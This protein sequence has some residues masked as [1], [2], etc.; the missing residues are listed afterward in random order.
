MA[1]L[2]LLLPLLAVTLGSCSYVYDLKA[3]VIGGRLAFVVDP[4]SRNVASCLNAID[5][6]ASGEVKAK[7]APGDDVSRVR[8]GTFWHERLDYGCADKF[9]IFYGQRFKGKRGPSG[10]AIKVVAAKPLRIG[11]VYEVSTT[12]GTGGYGGG[13]FKIMPD[14]TVS[15]LP[16]TPMVDSDDAVNSAIA[17][18]S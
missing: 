17:N 3:V 8:Y 1:R 11:I 10:Q 14:H 16:R 4:K 2:R 9:P 18:G 5:V 7:A 13:A 6:I 15:N 12:T